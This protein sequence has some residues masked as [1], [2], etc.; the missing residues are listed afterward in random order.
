MFHVTEKI[1]MTRIKLSNWARSNVRTGS[2]EI[3]EVEDKLT[4]L[5]G[6]SFSE[7]SIAH[8]NELI[9]KFN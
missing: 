4:S 8:K 9:S 5:L 6:N 2:F 3:R 1:K 7:E